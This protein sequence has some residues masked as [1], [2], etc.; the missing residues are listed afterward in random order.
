MKGHGSQTNNDVS[1]EGD[2]VHLCNSVA[3]TVTNTQE[4]QVHKDDVCECVE[5]LC[6]V[7]RDVVVLVHVR[8]VLMYVEYTR[9]VTWSHLFT[10]VQCGTLGAP[11][12]IS[13]FTVRPLKDQRHN[14][15][16]SPMQWS[17]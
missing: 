16:H 1:C 7:G 13:S 5:E 11:E 4:S 10:P 15:S 14:C 9:F 3:Q 8:I 12:A 17:A 6:N 2:Q